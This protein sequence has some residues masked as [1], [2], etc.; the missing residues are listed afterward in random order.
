MGVLLIGVSTI[1]GATNSTIKRFHVAPAGP[2]PVALAVTRAFAPAPTLR[3][4]SSPTT[5]ALPKKLTAL[6]AVAFS[7]A[8]HPMDV[9][10]AGMVIEV[11]AV[12]SAN[13]VEPIEVTPC[14]ISTETN[15]VAPVNE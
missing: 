6:S 5:G 12:A 9:T 11:S 4:A 14:G 1:C 10:L 2:K 15:L 8:Y 13:E 7:N 3:K